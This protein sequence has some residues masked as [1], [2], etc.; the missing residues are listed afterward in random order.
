MIWLKSGAAVHNVQQVSSHHWRIQ[1]VHPT[2]SGGVKCFFLA[3][4]T[5][6][7]FLKAILK[8]LTVTILISCLICIS[9]LISGILT[10]KNSG[11]LI[12]GVGRGGGGADCC[13]SLIVVG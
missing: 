11:C 5:I 9:K 13:K 4:V 6:M 10:S 3:M 1:G 12:C 8:V 7:F 2:D